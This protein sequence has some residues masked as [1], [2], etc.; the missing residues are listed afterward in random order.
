MIFSKSKGNL[1]SSLSLACTK[2]EGSLFG[3]L[4][5]S[6]VKQELKRILVKLNFKVTHSKNNILLM[7]LVSEILDNVK[8]GHD[9][10]PILRENIAK[11]GTEILNFQRENYQLEEPD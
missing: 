4:S 1:S 10:L 11:S 8:I 5:S 9:V 7:K 6:E 3:C 2:L